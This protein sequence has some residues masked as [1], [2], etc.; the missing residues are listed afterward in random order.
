MLYEE[1]SGFKIVEYY[2]YLQR[3]RGLPNP[4]EPYSKLLHITTLHALTSSA[5]L[6]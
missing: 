6:Q 3:Y 5:H 4:P 1:E 2:D